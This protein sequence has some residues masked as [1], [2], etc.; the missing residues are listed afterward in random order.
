MCLQEP[1]SREPLRNR[2]IFLL[3]ADAGLR[4]KEVAS[5]GLSI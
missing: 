5:V 1:I 4:A 2:V 3:N